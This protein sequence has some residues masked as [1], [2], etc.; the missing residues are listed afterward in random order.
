MLHSSLDRLARTK[1]RCH[2]LPLLFH[3]WY[4]DGCRGVGGGERERKKEE[5]FIA[6]AVVAGICGVPRNVREGK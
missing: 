3:H 6:T 2:F 5:A 4:C 1:N